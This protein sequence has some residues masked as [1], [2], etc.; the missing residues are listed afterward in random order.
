MRC[1]LRVPLAIVSLLPALAACQPD[2]H[3]QANAPPQG[4][5]PEHPVVTEY[6]VYHNDQG[7]LADRCIADIHFIPH[8]SDLSATGMARLERYAELLA[9]S[10]GKLH[11][12]TMITD[13]T[14]LQARL[15]TATAFLSEVLPSTRG[16]E[17]VRGMPGG[18]GMTGKEAIDAAAV[19]QQP[20]PRGTAYKLAGSGGG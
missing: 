5:A 11:Y 13:E 8:T 9:T 10:G 1:T 20:E 2:E 15:E 18:P 16:I 17:V 3:V 14:L 19:A 7:M 4:Y 6:Y 12:D